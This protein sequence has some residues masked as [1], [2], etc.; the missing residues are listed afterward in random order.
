MQQLHLSKPFCDLWRQ[1][2]PFERVKALQGDVLRAMKTRKTLRFHVNGGVYYV[3]M[4]GG[5]GWWEILKNLLQCKRPV[6]GAQNEWQAL[7]RLHEIGVE[8]MMPVAFG[9]RGHNPARMESFIITEELP[10]TRSLEDFC[11]NWP[12]TPPPSWLRRALIERVASMVGRMHRHGLNHRDCYICH[13]H[14]RMPDAGTPLHP[15]QVHLY[16]IDLHRAQLRRR[17]PPRWRIKDLA[18]LYFSSM[19]IGLTRADCCRFIRAYEEQ[20]LREVLRRRGRLWQRVASTAVALYRKHFGVA[21]GKI[22]EIP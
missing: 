4:H 16:V 5:I 12:T 13:F 20:P 21:P 17:V 1:S 10:G 6:I 9:R 19:D 8:T 3:K 14:L 22:H 11:A 18:G 7:R 15:E 2:D